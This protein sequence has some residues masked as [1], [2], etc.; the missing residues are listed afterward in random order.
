[1]ISNSDTIGL[2][3]PYPNRYVFLSKRKRCLHS[4]TSRYPAIEKKNIHTELTTPADAFAPA[5]ESGCPR[6]GRA[7]AGL[8]LS[9]SIFPRTHVEIRG[10]NG[11]GWRAPK[12][13]TNPIAFVLLL[14]LLYVAATDAVDLLLLLCCCCCCAA[15]EVNL[16]R[17]VAASTAC[18]SAAT[19]VN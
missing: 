17:A 1:M 4:D 5:S 18:C 3:R 2:S 15:S 6:G 10:R 8:P 11:P 16:V 9:V 12:L 19:K 14:L 13:H 7:Q